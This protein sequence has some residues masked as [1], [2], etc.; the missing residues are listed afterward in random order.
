MITRE[1]D[2]NINVLVTDQV[3]P[4]EMRKN[5]NKAVQALITM[6]EACWAREPTERPTANDVAKFLN[7]TLREILGTEVQLEKLKTTLADLTNRSSADN[8][9]YPKR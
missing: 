5:P 1:I 9:L 6:I 8:I 4:W 2:Q 3:I 7:E